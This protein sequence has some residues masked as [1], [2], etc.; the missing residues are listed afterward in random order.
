MLRFVTGHDQIVAEWIEQKMGGLV[1]TPHLAPGIVDD[2]GILRGGFLIAL[3]N[4]SC[5]ELTVYSEGALTPGVTRDLFRYVF[6]T[7]GIWRLQVRTDKRNRT[8]KRAAPKLGFRFEGV[9]RDFWGPGHDALLFYMTPA[10]C[11]W[12]RKDTISGLA[13]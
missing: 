12:L 2:D 8:I 13:L 3:H 5:A 10:H 7:L 11:R 1:V 4:P 6:D 9:A